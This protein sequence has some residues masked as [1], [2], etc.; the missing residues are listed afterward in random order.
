MP[1]TRPKKRKL[2]VLPLEPLGGDVFFP[3]VMHRIWFGPMRRYHVD[4]GE[5]LA[6]MN[7]D[8]EIA[9]WRRE[10]LDSWM[11]TEA[12]NAVDR[13]IAKRKYMI[14]SDIVRLAIVHKFGGIYIDSDAEP[15]RPI[16]PAVAGHSLIIS[17]QSGV[18]V[19]NHPI[20]GEPGHP[21]IG[22]LAD[23]APARVTPRVGGMAADIAG[24]HWITLEYWKFIDAGWSM[25]VF[26]TK[27]FNPY[28]WSDISLKGDTYAKLLAAGTDPLDAY[29]HAVFV[30]HFNAERTPR[31]GANQDVLNQELVEDVL[32]EGP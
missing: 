15:L 25:P 4:F 21:F 17:A 1:G 6:A 11:T 26:S 16:T 2:P 22:W 30:H 24:P 28:T 32:N 13:A 9:E 20:G 23:N 27:I 31:R 12:L 19:Q 14:A 8:W 5:R 29:P 10:D 18:T 3:K 7:P